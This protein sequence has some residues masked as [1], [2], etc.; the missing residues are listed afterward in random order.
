MKV[1]L[2]GSDLAKAR[3]WLARLGF[4]EVSRNPEVVISWG[5]DGTLLAAER[6]F[7][8]VPKLPIRDLSRYQKCPPHQDKAVL[9]ALQQGKLQETVVKKL[10]VS[11]KKIKK[12]ALN[13]VALSHQEPMT[14]VRFRLWV[15]K[16]PVGTEPIISDGLVI[17]TIFGATGYFS[18]ITRTVFDQGMGIALNN[19]TVLPCYRGTPF[20]ALVIS[21][22]A[23]IGVEISRGPA[24]LVTD[25]DREMVELTR[26]DRLTVTT[27][28][29][30]AVVLG[31][32]AFRCSVCRQKNTS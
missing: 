17:A 15:D 7:P 23:Q 30:E 5:G 25:N 28:T 2:Y 13:E 8:G 4:E 9:L 24:W 29:R 26:S 11:F 20:S 10:A 31:L 14:A 32:E 18:S 12:L 1:G 21:A 22:S 16:D 19:P 27:S 6:E 3:R